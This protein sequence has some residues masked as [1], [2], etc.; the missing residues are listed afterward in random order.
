[1]VSSFV[2]GTIDPGLLVV[3]GRIKPG[4]SHQQAEEEI[5]EI[6]ETLILQ[7]VQDEELRKVK[8]QA[9]VVLEFGEVEVMNRA[10]NLAFAKLSGD[11]NLV[12]QEVRHIESVST[13]DI[14]RVA[15]EILISQWLHA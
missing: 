11:T 15:T 5:T 12:N 13:A 2:L 7:G 10:M 6:L 3:S 4:I 14:K 9:E 8:N 1:S